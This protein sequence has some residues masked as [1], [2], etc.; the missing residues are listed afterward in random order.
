MDLKE[1]KTDFIEFYSGEIFRK[2][3]LHMSL[4]SYI[5][6]VWEVLQLY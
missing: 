6:S 4:K 5:Y 1:G 3:L 2:Q